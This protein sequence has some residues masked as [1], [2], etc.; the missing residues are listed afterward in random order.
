MGQIAIQIP[1]VSG[2]QDIVVDVKINGVSQG[3]YTYKVEFF[4][5]KDCKNPTGNRVDCVR[6][7]LKNYDPDWE[8]YN[9]DEP[10]ADFIAITFRRKR[11]LD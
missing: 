6:E 11:F 1:R 8:V 10:T 5:W 7:I 3:R 2:E 4:Y 9:M